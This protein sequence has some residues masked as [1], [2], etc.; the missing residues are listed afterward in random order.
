MNHFLFADLLPVCLQPFS[1]SPSLS[2]CFGAH[3]LPQ[4]TLRSVCDWLVSDASS[5][6]WGS[7][8]VELKRPHFLWV[9]PP[10]KQR[11]CLCFFFWYFPCWFKKL[12][13]AKLQYCS[14]CSLLLTFQTDPEHTDTQSENWPRD[15]QQDNWPRDRKLTRKQSC[16]HAESGKRVWTRAQLTCTHVLILMNKLTDL[17]SHFL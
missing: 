15:R 17:V 8:L 6:Y 13:E 3:P 16:W 4:E 10:R 14:C 2:T 7:W 12:R 5:D 9:E 11:K 1:L